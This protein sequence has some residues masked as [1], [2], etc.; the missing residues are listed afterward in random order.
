MRA[1]VAAGLLVCACAN[2]PPQRDPD[3]MRWQGEHPNAAQQLCSFNLQYPGSSMRMREWVLDHPVQAQQLLDWAALNPGPTI[4]R[5]FLDTHP[6]FTGFSPWRDPAVLMLYEWASSNPEAAQALADNPHGLR[7][8][9]DSAG[10][11]DR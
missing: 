6:G 7:A 4:P 11:H 3:L 5:A 2:G 9:F 8:A 1:A 10:C